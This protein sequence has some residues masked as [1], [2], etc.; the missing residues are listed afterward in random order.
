M[1]RIGVWTPV[2]PVL[3][4]VCSHVSWLVLDLITT[5]AEDPADEPWGFIRLLGCQFHAD[6]SYLHGRGKLLSLSIIILL[7]NLPVPVLSCD[8]SWL[9]G[10]HLKLVW[11]LKNPSYSPNLVVTLPE[12]HLHVWNSLLLP[13][14]SS[15]NKTKQ[16][17][18]RH[19]QLK[20]NMYLVKRTHHLASPS[21]PGWLSCSLHL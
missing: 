7:L 14:C 17:N 9:E 18:E 16:I 5:P 8:W 10:N 13:C 3:V 6:A 15:L 20:S 4:V 2:F 11:E 12:E 21:L 1:V 19:C